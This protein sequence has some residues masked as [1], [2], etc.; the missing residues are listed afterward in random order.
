MIGV[1]L[2]LIVAGL[3]EAFARQLVDNTGGR[4]A[5]GGVMLVLWCG[6]FFVWRGGEHAGRGK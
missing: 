5:I 1:V 3:L 6:Y 2:M 4:L